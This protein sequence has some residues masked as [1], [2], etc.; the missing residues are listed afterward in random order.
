[1]KSN[2][3]SGSLKS[4][5]SQNKLIASLLILLTISVCILVGIIVAINNDNQNYIAA[6]ATIDENAGNIANTSSNDSATADNFTHATEVTTETP[7]EA[8]VS[9][10][11]C[12]VG[13]ILVHEGVYNM[14]CNNDGSYNFDNLFKNISG[15]IKQADI[16]IVN[17]ETILGGT[18]LG[19]SAYP[20]FNSP[21][22]IGDAEVNAGFNVILHATNHTFDSGENAVTATL[23]F[24]QNKYPDIATLGVYRN[25]TDADNIYVY[26]KDGF[27][28][29]ILNY[30]YG[31]NGLSLPS[32]SDITIKLLDDET[33][34]KNEI[35]LAKSISDMVVVCPHWGTEYSYTPS[36]EQ[37][38]WADIFL[39]AGVDIVIGTHPHVLQPVEMLTSDSGH[40]MLVY[41]SLGNCVSWQNEIP[42]MLGGMAKIT[43]TKQNG[44][45][46]ISDYSIEPLV[47]HLAN[48]RSFSVYKL[49]D[50]TES[51]AKNSYINNYESTCTSGK[52]YCGASQLKIS[53]HGCN[54]NFSVAYCKELCK[55]ILGDIYSA[56]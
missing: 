33:I 8:G 3:K 56:S 47:T 48:D 25:E 20:R 36:T 31:T 15:D 42:R 6:N 39:D 40:Q 35:A 21:Q 50:Y 32:S 22:E 38:R 12:M 23:D 29:S 10:D 26:E 24:W 44:T 53:T 9:L 17:Q 11:I 4:R 30:T 34:V 54:N 45:A 43:V 52:C 13:D 16:K 41:Y 7:S 46:Y 14:G 37:K 5:F 27:K 1:M 55:Y 18:K 49:S 51:L 28:I 19:L 2:D